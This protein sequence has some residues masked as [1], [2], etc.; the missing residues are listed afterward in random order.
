MKKLFLFA[1]ALCCSAAMFAANKTFYLKPNANWSKDG[2]K[3]AIYGFKSADN[4]SNGWSAFMTAEPGGAY[5]GE[6]SDEY[7]K[8]I[9]VRFNG[10]A[11]TPAW[12]ADGTPDKDKKKW[13]Q[14]KDLDVPLDAKNL[15]TIADG[16]WDKGDG[17]WSEY[18]APVK[19][20]ITFKVKVP[21]GTTKC[22]IAGDWNADGIWV[23]KEM[24]AV[25]SIDYQFE[26][27]ANLYESFEYKYCSAASWDNVE[28]K[29]DGTDLDA[30]RTYKGGI[31]EVAKFKEPAATLFKSKAF[32]YKDGMK[33]EE[34]K[35]DSLVIEVTYDAAQ[36]DSFIIVSDKIYK[37]AVN[38][39]KMHRTNCTDWGLQE[40]AAN[41]QDVA[42]DIDMPGK[43]T[44]IWKPSTMKISV[45][46]P[47]QKKEDITY[48]VKVPAGTAK[49]YIAGDWNADGNW[50]F[51]EMSAVN[52]TDY[53]F[54]YKATQQ[55]ASF[56]YKYCAADS[57]DYVEVTADGKSV[58]NRTYKGGIDEVAKFKTPAPKRE[59][60]LVCGE[61]KA[62]NPAMLLHAFGNGKDAFS[63][64]MVVVKE[65]NDTVAY[66]AEIPNDLDSLIFVRAKED[67]TGWDKLIWD[68][69]NKNVWGQSADLKI[70]GDT[71]RFISW[72]EG[73]K[74]VVAFGAAPV[75]GGDTW[76]IK[77]PQALDDWVW[78]EMDEEQDG[79][80]SYEAAWFGGGANLN[81]AMEDKDAI[82]VE[83]AKMDFGEKV[84]PAEG[85][86]CKFIWNPTTQKLAVEYAQG[87]ENIYELN[88]NAPM[89]NVLGVEVDATFKGVVIQNGHKF[90]R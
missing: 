26:Y 68:G 25:N 69:E 14:T 52:S 80:W 65:G 67:V 38:P 13:N 85:T 21:T 88:V 73:G 47:E 15:Y 20:D 81:T 30:N 77:L 42:I 61:L 40:D 37:V 63:A 62:D 29:A 87:I 56:Q 6:I 45:I 76:Y 33:F 31:D 24:T 7:D 39:D 27:T 35:A 50:V 8:I 55:L 9:F 16:A 22:F 74:F 32:G 72:G 36:V 28:L 19:K 90:I 23:F 3:F 58:D 84:A 86:A 54:E 60:V 1:M 41:T 78:H 89:Y 53:Q 4:E 49:C 66:K 71:A 2:A 10:D 51:K 48:K 17:T 5:K 43:Y 83:D 12:D 57:W 64:L 18:V 70:E 44:Y 79:T 59:I 11:T 46:Y 75:P 34:K 82:Y